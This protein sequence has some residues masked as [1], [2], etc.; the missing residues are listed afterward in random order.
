[1]ISRLQAAA[2][3]VNPASRRTLRV[4]DEGRTLI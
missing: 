3:T 2:M 1:V 4:G